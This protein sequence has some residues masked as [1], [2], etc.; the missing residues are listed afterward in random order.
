MKEPIRI[1][2]ILAQRPSGGI[3]SY[4]LNMHQNIDVSKVQF[5][6]IVCD[7]EPSS[8]FDK[9]VKE[10]GGKVYIFS[11]LKYSNLF[12]YIRE[13]NNFFKRHN[14]Y[15]IVHGHFT[16][17]ASIYLSIAKL[18]GVKYRMVHSHSINYS[19]YWTRAVRNF[20]LQLPLRYI[21]NYYVACSKE[22]GKFLF[23][24][25]LIDQN[26]VFI[27]NNAIEAEKFRFNKE[28]RL[29]IRKKYNLEN[30]YVIGHVGRLCHAKNH[31]FLIEVFGKIHVRNKNAKLIIIG[32][33]ELEKEIRK[34][35]IS[36]NLNELVLFMGYRKDT[37]DL[38]QAVDI[39]TLP[40]KYEGLGIAAIEAQAAG[41]R[42]IVSNNVP[43]EVRITNLVEYMSFDEGP[44]KWAEEI[45]RDM[46]YKRRDTYK[47]I[48]D[49]GFD[50]KSSV[51]TLEN[52]YLEIQNK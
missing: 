11:P 2:Q 46:D 49:S 41:L 52:L 4:L 27:S 18:H 3:E 43:R 38:L 6:Y 39:F 16:G 44:E 23:G 13:M 32:D 33:G 30:N 1:L 34:K 8:D 45:L 12:K 15:K 36:L 47:E 5:D 42:T 14:E 51:R 10:L 50:V 7:V 28:M 21:A 31:E 48:V 26:K 19:D 20:I 29:S 35:V 22:A 25:K 40:S 24:K 9:K 17:L 37:C